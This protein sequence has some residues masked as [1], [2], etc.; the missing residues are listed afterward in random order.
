MDARIRSSRSALATQVDVILSNIKPYFK[1]KYVCLQRPEGVDF[2][3]QE[4]DVGVETE[5]RYSLRTI[6]TLNH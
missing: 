2:L 4:L 6:G 3:E 5:L 1:K